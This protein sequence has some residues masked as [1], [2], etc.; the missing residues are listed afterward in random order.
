MIFTTT[1]SYALRILILMA[2]SPDKGTNALELHKALNIKLQYMR[3][4]LTTLANKGFVISNRGRSGGFRLAK[5][6]NEILL[7]DIIDA[8]EGLE[9][10]KGCVLGFKD[11]R[12]IDVC[13]M[14]SVW[15][16]SKNTI[17]ATFSNTRLS[18]LAT[19][20]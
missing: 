12:R 8:M 20:N 2:N 5:S 1:T 7:S 11:C 3:R 14:H 4:V 17:L 10:F 6:P 16:E 19:E 13:K 18:D 9:N 15:M